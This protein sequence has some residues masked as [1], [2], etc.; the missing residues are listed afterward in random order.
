MIK[1][2]LYFLYIISGS[3]LT[4]LLW[5]LQEIKEETWTPAW[6]VENEVL[7]GV[8]IFGF[9]VLMNIIYVRRASTSKETIIKRWTHMLIKHMMEQY[10]AKNSY[11]TRITIYRPMSGWR[12]WLW[13][14]WDAG[15]CNI[16]NNWSHNRTTLYW[17]RIP[18]PFSTY[19]K[20]TDRCTSS[21]EDRSMTIFKATTRGMSYNGIAD[22]CYRDDEDSLFAETTPLNILNLPETYP[23]DE[24]PESKVIKNYMS[25][26]YIGKEY[27]DTLKAM[28]FTAFQLFAFPLRDAEE[29][30]WGI[31]VVDS[32]D[33]L[34]QNLE[35]ILTPHIGDYQ[36]LFRSMCNSLKEN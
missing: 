7:I 26:T 20:M 21:K 22:K 34:K 33:E 8:L 25:E 27:Y 5:L 15:I 18:L 35:T 28:N 14:M 29:N 2:T 32:E 24:S 3:L 11:K 19:L 10:L 12:T 31:V 16:R 6:V 1:N 9:V 4:A 36:V 30:I 23:M 17:K 13:Y